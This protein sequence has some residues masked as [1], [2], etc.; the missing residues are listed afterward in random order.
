VLPENRA[1]DRG[2]S[3]IDWLQHA[4]KAEKFRGSSRIDA[5]A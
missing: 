1:H 3:G 4:Q 2:W 5:P